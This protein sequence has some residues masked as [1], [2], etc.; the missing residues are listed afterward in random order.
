MYLYQFDWTG[1]LYDCIHRP[2]SALWTLLTVPVNL[3][4][5]NYNTDN[6]D[7]ATLICIDEQ[8]INEI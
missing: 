8:G 4:S 5:G 2:V 1:E 6:L 3:V 7:I